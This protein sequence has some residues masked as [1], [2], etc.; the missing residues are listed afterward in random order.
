MRQ[1]THLALCTLLSILAMIGLLATTAA[2]QPAGQQLSQP[3]PAPSQAEAPAP[4][5]ATPTA[6]SWTF[7]NPFGTLKL[8]KPKMP[9]FQWRPAFSPTPETS[10]GFLD[11]PV[12]RIKSATR[13]A[14]QRTR[15]AWNSTVEKLKFGGGQGSGGQ[16]SSEP[17]FF[18]RMFGG[19][20]EPE[21]ARTVTEFLAQERPGAE[22]R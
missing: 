9:Q 19:D 10:P 1:E 15:T 3:W 11:G 4:E 18:A 20:P 6:E 22:R 7:T 13:G 8:P 14:A 21:G 12:G 2:G 16:P 5:A 17:G